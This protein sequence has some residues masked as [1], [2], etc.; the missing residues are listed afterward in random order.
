METS[1][2]LNTFAKTT[3]VKRPREIASYSRDSSF[4]IT[5]SPEDY[6]HFFFQD[7]DLADGRGYDLKQ[8][9][10]PDNERAFDYGDMS[11]FL[12]AIMTH[13]KTKGKKIDA[14]LITWRGLIRKLM[15][16]PFENRDKF[17]LNV[18]P[19]D[20][21]LFMQSDVDFERMK[22]QNEQSFRNEQAQMAMYSGYKFERLTTI[23]KPWGKTKRSE[24]ESRRRAPIDQ[25]SQ[26]ATVVKTTIGTTDLVIGAEVDGVWDFKPS[27]GSDPLKHYVELKCTRVIDNPKSIF[28]FERKLLT[29]WAQCFLIGVPR[30]IY[31]FRDDQFILRAIEEFQTDQIP[32]QLKNNPLHLQRQKEDPSFKVQ[33]KPMLSIKFLCGLLEWIENSIPVDDESKTYTLEFDPEKNNMSLSIRQNSAEKSEKLL[34]P[35]SG[36]EGGILSNEFRQWRSELKLL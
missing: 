12:E 33:N 25:I 7:G 27:D 35:Y 24:I 31:G 14:K 19:F 30:I 32:I 34:S 20:G 18:I 28:N 36:A 9:F 26:Y 5:Q 2:S 15:L 22:Y 4:K 11:G 1:Y 8:G 23:D 13:E 17:V 10:S 16:L 29:A 3:N 6:P 21:Q